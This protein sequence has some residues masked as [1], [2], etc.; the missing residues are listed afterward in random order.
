MRLRR[1]SQGNYSYQ[2]VSDEQ[3][4][5]DTLQELADAQNK[6]YNVDADALK[7]IMIKF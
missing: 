1:D 2:F 3:Q 5:A 6:L 7:I 4:V